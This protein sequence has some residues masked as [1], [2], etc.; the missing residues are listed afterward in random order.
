M[1]YFNKMELNTNSQEL[2]S[3]GSEDEKDSE[4]IFVELDGKIIKRIEI[5]KNFKEEINFR[6]NSHND[7]NLLNGKFYLNY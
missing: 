3:S 2:S 6:N 5:T 4:Y 1:N 7:K